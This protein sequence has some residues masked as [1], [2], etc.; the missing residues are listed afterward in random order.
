MLKAILLVFEPLATW[1]K[2]FLARRG[3]VYILLVYL[4]PLLLITSAGEGFGLV[5]WGKLR[6]EVREIARPYLFKPAEAALFEGAQVL[7]SLFVVFIGAH[8]VKSVGETF[9]GRHTYLQAFSAVAYGLSPLFLLRLLDA[10]P[11]V[12]LWVTWS[13]GIVLSIAVLYNGL[14][15][16]M[17]PDPP[18]AFG[19]FLMSSVLLTLITGLVRFVTWW[20]LDRQVPQAGTDD[21]PLIAG[22]PA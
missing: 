15:R 12:S 11:G 13:I 5:H 4:L 18:H 21:S 16:M 1:E 19:L 17:E 7:L 6:G 22:A 3:M 10:F 14:P 2:I 20:Y 9:H 8:L